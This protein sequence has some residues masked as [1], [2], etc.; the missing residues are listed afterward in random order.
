V[1]DRLADLP[2]AERKGWSSLWADVDSVRA[3]ARERRQSSQERTV[4]ATSP[5]FER[6]SA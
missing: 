5:R 1:R 2:E 4:R 6:R 3:R